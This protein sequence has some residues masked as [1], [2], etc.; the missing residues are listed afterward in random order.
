[1]AR[2]MLTCRDFAKPARLQTHM[3]S[4]HGMCN[5]PAP[6]SSSPNN[7]Y[8]APISLTSNVT[9]FIGFN[10]IQSP[11]GSGPTCAC[12]FWL[13]RACA[14]TPFLSLPCP[15]ARGVSFWGVFLGVVLTHC[16]PED[17]SLAHAQQNITT[18]APVSGSQ[19]A[20]TSLPW[21]PRQ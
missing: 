8:P 16:R 9:L 19:G 5:L 18:W 7:K 6:Q 12:V 11:V 3:E 20:Q 4:W 13:V 1:M 10:R 2:T 17:H 21:D 15:R 14:N